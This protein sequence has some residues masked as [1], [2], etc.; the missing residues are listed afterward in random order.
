MN[1]DD[2]Q[3]HIQ[4]LYNYIVFQNGEALEGLNATTDKGRVYLV[5]KEGER[6]GNKNLSNEEPNKEKKM[7]MNIG[8]LSE[9]VKTDEEDKDLLQMSEGLGDVSEAMKHA[10][11]RIKEDR[12]EELGNALVH[13]MRNVNAKKRYYVSNIRQIRRD[14]E[15]EIKASKESLNKLDMAIKFASET[16]NYIPL[17]M[18]AGFSKHDLGISFQEYRDHM[19][20]FEEYCSK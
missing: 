8:V 14:A 3:D 12:Q 13:V 10:M 17:A 6:K 19:K 2:W 1:D 16:N 4:K 11:D 7:T 18:L 9:V 15:S 20:D 5:N